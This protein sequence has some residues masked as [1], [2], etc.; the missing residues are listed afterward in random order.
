MSLLSFNKREEYAI[1]D[2]LPQPVICI[3]QDKKFQWINKA[4]EK[5]L[6]FSRD[7][8]TQKSIT[9]IVFKPASTELPPDLD[10]EKPA[11]T[12][13]A[14]SFF[15]QFPWKNREGKVVNLL[16]QYNIQTFSS[17]LDTPWIVAIGLE[18]TNQF[19]F[20]SLI[21]LFPSPLAVVDLT[22]K[23]IAANKAYFQLLSLPQQNLTGQKHSSI[24]PD[25]ANWHL[26]LL[27][28][29]LEGQVAF[30]PPLTY[31]EVQGGIRW[32]KWK[33]F[34]WLDPQG[35]VLGA[36]I[37]AEDVSE[38]IDAEQKTQREQFFLSEVLDALPLAVYLKDKSGRYIH[39]NEEAAKIV[40][41]PKH[42]VLGKTASAYLT[43]EE[44]KFVEM[45]DRQILTKKQP[46]F[47]IEKNW[48]GNRYRY[49]YSGKKCVELSKDNDVYIVGFT[50]E[51][52]QS[53]E[54]ELLVLSQKSFM[55]QVLDADPNLIFVQDSSG[56]LLFANKA[57][58]ALLSK[59]SIPDIATNSLEDYS[60]LQQHKFFTLLKAPEWAIEQ[61]KT[62][63]REVKLI[64]D[65]SNNASSWFQVIH[66]P[67][68]I[69]S[70][71][72][73]ML[74]IAVDITEKKQFADQLLARNRELE[75]ILKQYSEQKTLMQHILD[76]DPSLI[77]VLDRE[78]NFI[79]TNQAF[80]DFIEKKLFQEN[81]SPEEAIKKFAHITQGNNP[82]T[83]VTQELQT[84]VY[85]EK[86][87]N[88]Q[89]EEIWLHTVR[90]PLIYEDG[91]INILGISVDITQKKKNE[92]AILQRNQQLETILA[93]LE[94][95][96]NFMQQVLDTDP[97]LVY[98][99]NKKGEYIFANQTA[100]RV[101]KNKGICT[102]AP[103]PPSEEDKT[104]FETRE[105]ID[106]EVLKKL[107][108]L[109]TEEPFSTP[110]G[111]ILWF[112]T[113][114]KPLLR[115]GGTYNLLVVSVN[116]TELKRVQAELLQR[117]EE[118]ESVLRAL[119]DIY[120][121][122]SAEGSIVDY[123]IPPS[124]DWLNS[125]PQII[126]SKLWEIFPSLSA[127]AVLQTLEQVNNQPKY[128]ATL[129]YVHIL[130]GKQITY[131]ARF[132]H[133]V[134]GGTIVVIRNVTTEKNIEKAL[135]QS[136][137]LYRAIIEDHTELICRYLPDLTLTFAN[138][139]YCRYV[140]KSATEV[141]G[142]PFL[143]NIFPEDRQ[144]LVQTIDKLQLS[145]PVATLEHRI[146][147]PDQQVGWLQ[148]TIRGIFDEAGVPLVFQ[149]VG[150]DI[151]SLKLTE[152]ALRESKRFNEQII[153]TI[154]QVLFIYK[155]EQRSFMYVNE[156]AYSMLGLEPEFFFR[157]GPSAIRKMVHPEDWQKLE[158][159]ESELN[160]SPQ[161]IIEF[162]VRL[163]NNKGEWRWF[164]TR[165]TVFEKNAVGSPT[166]ILGTAMDITERKKEQELA[167]KTELLY[168]TVVENLQETLFYTDTNF[169]WQ[170]L[171]PSWKD[172]SGFS[173]E[174]T[175]YKNLFDYIHPLDRP[176]LRKELEELLAETRTEVWTQLRLLNSDHTFHWVEIHTKIRRDET[177]VI[178]GT[179]GSLI[180][181][182]ERKK[183]EEALIESQER[184]NLALESTQDGVWDWDLKTNQ[185]YLSPQWLKML[186]YSI[187]EN[188]PH[189]INLFNLCHP[190]DIEDFKAAIV[191]HLSGQ[192]P[193][194]EKEIRIQT[195]AGEWLWV[196]SRAKVVA[197]DE[198]NNPLRLVGTTLNITERKRIAMEL[199]KAKEEAEAADKAKSEFLAAMSH[200]I[201]TPMNGIIGMTDLL[202]NT[203]LNE[204]QL[205]FV[206]TIRNSSEALLKIINH[207][208]DFSKVE[209]GKLELEFQFIDL[210]EFIDDIFDLFAP[211]TLSKNIELVQVIHPN[212]PRYIEADPVRLRQVLV[213][214]LNN[215]IKFTSQG[216]IILT[217]EK[218][219]TPNHLL[220]CVCDTGIGIEPEAI[221]KI[222][223][224]FTQA[225]YSTTRKYGGT[226]LGLTISK[227]LVELMGGT[228]EVKSKPQ[229]GS[230]F[231]VNLPLDSNSPYRFEWPTFKQKNILI[232]CQ[233]WI[234]QGALGYACS[235]LSPANLFEVQNISQ[236]QAIINQFTIDLFIIDFSSSDESIAYFLKNL[237][238]FS[239]LTNIIIL[240]PLNST[241]IFKYDNLKIYPIHKPIKQIPLLE[242]IINI[243]ENRDVELKKT[244][245]VPQLDPL[246]S[247]KIPLQILV[248]EDNP[249]NQRFTQLILE[250]LG[251]KP[252]IVT[253]GLQV[254]EALKQKSY[255]LLLMDLNMPEL[256]GL[257]TM[258]YLTSQN[259]EHRYPPPV[260]V[261]LT[262]NALKEEKERALNA[263]MKDYIVKPIHPIDIQNCIQKLFQHPSNITSVGQPI[264]IPWVDKQE[265]SLLEKD[266]IDLLK[267]IGQA[268]G[269][270]TVNQ[271][272]ELFEQ[273][274]LEFFSEVKNLKGAELKAKYHKFKGSAFSIGAKH[275]GQLL[276]QL[277]RNTLEDQV[278][279]ST[280]TFEQLQQLYHQTLR[281]L[282]QELSILGS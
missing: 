64:E 35:T 6:G 104:N 201:R 147:L 280:F 221:E 65:S 52:T 115:P 189:K 259:T 145:Q 95:Q 244:V 89:G 51:I 273:S 17:S 23:Y 241:S 245:T 43:P 208:L 128:T 3:G 121:R 131:E 102:P 31:N 182:R 258:Q 174:Q 156:R 135:K 28:Q 265:S 116:I 110:N 117:N 223:K 216:A 158:K 126:G 211:Q 1:L 228:I 230:C 76:T 278:T 151:T 175:L 37:L 200:E 48:I 88:P 222:F 235:L 281:A 101:L 263:G 113:I 155:L 183:V 224:A 68:L 198:E 148:W 119:P 162:E 255:D 249:V 112:R 154:P 169:N 45:E 252:D 127:N 161:S 56:N 50:L 171:S 75:V 165:V 123:K 86:F 149:A 193:I 61:Q 166:T 157:L 233:N 242:L 260:V 225:D 63:L 152:Q 4:A 2:R 229:R 160:N 8:I 187:D 236:A 36:F 253:N 248:A 150:R 202:L 146:T 185:M 247:T 271:L 279:I 136:E 153:A 97:N 67:L 66:K 217:V 172:I 275:L 257:Q 25:L 124:E 44:A 92:L 13:E 107:E 209:S 184:L 203:P 144:I 55:E 137:A 46:L 103:H 197:W 16:W 269:T 213:N 59:S 231:Y 282:K 274:A 62:I 105:V 206:E 159:L 195:F 73:Q 167:R 91:T 106:I 176:L 108:T 7:E 122:L 276:E 272:V 5:L 238:G 268:K 109:E 210:A 81:L 186:G 14:I 138:E 111:E 21:H 141:L 93:E 181:I 20:N 254:V 58:K 34:P 267:K 100:Q 18:P 214:L 41:L 132:S 32:L 11:P 246:L 270:E 22:G 168:K 30:S 232:L 33:F 9:E 143:P 118:L 163:R 250:G 199:Q 139:A 38:L 140:G 47:Q 39:F 133:Y 10:I 134:Y 72:A 215:A 240:L 277:E 69:A 85:E 114:R 220:F 79:F 60:L 129:E 26:P 57:L 173:I 237:S 96:R 15:F 178:L 227:H 94:A 19:F 42:Q 191:K 54:A 192:T 77:Y 180:D 74:T 266:Q 40:G 256:D 49:F 196:L 239:N 80:Y 212:I 125:F 53:K 261:A 90:K 243:F 234:T 24:F 71:E 179:V 188:D 194:L 218:S 82:V 142:K 251:Y 207:I 204:M 83:A 170:F 205:E 262:A 84:L 12:V 164:S 29:A 226:G 264:S 27:Q 87:V 130:L 78:G 190:D 177:N 219:E 99:R 98:V 120:F 70:Q